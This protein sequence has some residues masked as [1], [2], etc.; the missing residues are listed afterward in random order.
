MKKMLFVLAVLV[1][2]FCAQA[3]IITVGPPGSGADFNR[4]QDAIDHS[5]AADTIRVNPWVYEETVRFNG[6]AVKLTSQDP[7]IPSIVESTIISPPSG[8]AV[9]FA[10]GET[11]SSIITG[12][13]IA[14]GGI[15]CDGTSPMISKNIIRDC[16]NNG[17][18]GANGAAPLILDN[19]ITSNSASGIYE[20]HGVISGNIV[21]YNGD[22]GGISRCSGQIIGN[23]ISNNFSSGSGGGLY[24][25][26]GEIAGNLIRGNRAAGDGGGVYWA[27]GP[28]RG[29]VI[30]AN[31][32]GGYGGGLYRCSIGV[33]HNIIAGNQADSGGGLDTCFGT[34]EHNTF[35]GNRAG[36]G[37]AM[38]FVIGVVTNNIIA[39]NEADDT[40]SLFN[41]NSNSYN[42]FWPSA[43]DHFGGGSLAG[44][45]DAIRDPC[46]AADGYWDANGTPGDPGDDF[47]VDGDYHLRSKSGRWDSTL[48]L[49]VYDSST[50]ACVDAG[51]PNSAWQ[52]EYWPHGGRVNAG[53]YGNTGEASMSLSG[54]GNVADLNLDG[55]VDFRDLAL[56][57][58]KWPWHIPLLR[59][60]L[61]RSGAVSMADYAI[62]VANWQ[63]LPLPSPN[64]MTWESEPA[65]ISESAITMTAT[66]ASSSDGMGVEY[67]FEEVSGN[68]GGSDSGWQ[69]S[70]SY[71]DSGLESG[72]EY[73][74]RVKARNKGNKVATEFSEIRSAVTLSGPS[75]DPMTW[76]A[77]PAAT[78]HDAITM[79]ATAASSSDGTGVEYF[80][81]EVSGNAGGSDSGWQDNPSYTDT[82]LTGGTTYC[83]R[84]KA[85]N[86]GNKLETGFSEQRCA[87]TAEA[88]APTPD[89]MTWA[90]APVATSAESITM[91][92]TTGSPGD[93]TAVEYLFERIGGGTSGWQG[94]PV[95][96]E[97]GLAKQTTYCYRVKAR[98]AGN[99]RETAWSEVRCAT[100]PCDDVTPPSFPVPPGYWEYEP[101]ECKHSFSNLDW[102]AEMVAAEAIDDSGYVEYFFE[103]IDDASKSSG[104]RISRCYEV[105]LGRPDQGYSFRVKARDACGNETSWSPAV[106]VRRCPGGVCPPDVCGGP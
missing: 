7:D 103:C 40:D 50:S 70:S 4:I 44:P 84:L 96:T 78:G 20:C 67:F 69:D 97:T 61:D 60:D 19:T 1:Q 59:E 18:T 52:E 43:S 14:G 35:V 11:N 31:K 16:P 87:T 88:P 21:S 56:L 9:R 62:L 41:V 42:S 89:P 66:A 64:P 58:D 92:A 104:W 71:T 28:V 27:G 25:C 57:V 15:Y 85:R 81:E 72:T 105:F 53:R 23:E 51:D 79:T 99:L 38:S 46:F 73:S 75:P 33:S 68:A 91:T 90:I 82:G 17:I 49:W 54:E 5:S 102:W 30:V 65:P 76:S 106:L 45:G 8:Y 48:E 26:G 47:W 3:K 83:Y 32:A 22:G 29:N 37:G 98:N 80:F 12:F 86:K 34:I 74:Y 2:G 94:S 13:T 77:E 100:T 10:F 24:R 93:G 36:V 101:C 55:L 39:F 6:R 95:Y 63:P